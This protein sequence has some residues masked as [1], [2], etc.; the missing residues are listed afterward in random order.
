[1]TSENE[2]PLNWPFLTVPRSKT[3]VV[4]ENVRKNMLRTSS[5]YT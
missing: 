5:I 2:A 3:V 1:M 4:A